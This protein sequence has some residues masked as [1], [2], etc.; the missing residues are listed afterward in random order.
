MV[1][2]Q[3][4]LK[5]YF[6]KE[7]NL[8]LL[9]TENDHLKFDEEYFP[10][11]YLSMFITLSGTV[12]FK[13]NMHVSRADSS[14]IQFF[15]RNEAVRFIDVSEDNSSVGIIFSKKY[16]N[17]ILIHSHSSLL[18]ADVHPCLE[19]TDEQRE[20]ILEF[21]RAIREKKEEGVADNNPVIINLIVGMLFHIGR[22]YEKW[23][24]SFPKESDNKV[25]SRFV[26]LLYDNYKDHRDV[27]FYADNLNLSK[28]RFT[29]VI[30]NSVGMS[31]FQCIERYTILKIC[32]QLKN[33]DKSIKQLAFEYNFADDSHFCKYFRKHMGQSALDFRNQVSY[34]NLDLEL[35]L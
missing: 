33:T 34:K 18:L 9:W 2:S 20:V 25:V 28:S 22:Y 6:N 15:S 14:H 13:T 30:K 23:S 11:D 5:D 26:A 8:F 1:I 35:Q 12:D 31:P 10:L 7:E 19:V 24:L 16:W 27:S 4:I 17:H 32:S 21:Y 29:E 3:Q